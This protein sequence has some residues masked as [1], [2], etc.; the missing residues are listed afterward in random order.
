ME[1]DGGLGGSI[2]YSRQFAKKKVHLKQEQPPVCLTNEN[3]EMDTTDRQ[4]VRPTRLR[5]QRTQ[6]AVNTPKHRHMI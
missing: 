2:Q 6:D 1:V 3:M 4:H 5:L